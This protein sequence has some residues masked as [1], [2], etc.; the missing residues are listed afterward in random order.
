MY[1]HGE[2]VNKRGV[3][4]VLHILTNGDYEDERIRR[5]I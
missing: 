3:T 1:I 5:G 4:V 2:F